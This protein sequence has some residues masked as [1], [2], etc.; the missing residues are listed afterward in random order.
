MAGGEALSP[1]TEPLSNTINVH[2]PKSAA[3]TAVSEGSSRGNE[4]LTGSQPGLR[5]AVSPA[6]PVRSS[7]FLNGLLRLTLADERALSL[8]KGGTSS[9]VS[10]TD[11]TVALPDT[12]K[13]GVKKLRIVSVRINET[14]TIL[15]ETP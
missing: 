14:T 10:A 9:N 13:P 6:R 4:A 11:S 3:L 1:Q 5:I 12:G 8:D 7:K 2:V 15:V